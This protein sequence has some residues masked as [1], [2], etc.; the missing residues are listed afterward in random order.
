M[1]E[2]YLVG[3][4][5]TV[6]ACRSRPRRARPIGLPKRVPPPPFTLPFSTSTPIASSI[7]RC[8]AAVSLRLAAPDLLRC[9]IDVHAIHMI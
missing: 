9:P 8:K 1:Y 5:R 2:A 4:H 6:V 7:A 3:Q